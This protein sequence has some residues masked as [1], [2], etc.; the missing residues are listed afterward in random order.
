[1]SDLNAGS[2]PGH[3]PDP[4]PADQIP[5][6]FPPFGPSNPGEPDLFE[7]VVITRLLG[8]KPERIWIHVLLFALTLAATTYIGAGNWVAF[9][10]RFGAV[11]P[12][13]EWPVVLWNGLW[14]SLTL[15]LIL[16]AHEAG[17]Y[18]ACRYYRINASL[19]YFLPA[20][21]PFI[22]GTFGAFIRIREPIRTKTM[23]FD[24]GAAGPF[25]GFLVAV[26]ALVI[27]CSLSNI[28]RLPP[29]FSG[30]ELGEPLLFKAVTSLVWGR[31]PDG[32]SINLHPMAFAAWFGLLVT[33]LNLIPIGQFDGGHISYAAFGKRSVWVTRGAVGA[34]VALCFHS[35]SWIMWTA[36]AVALLVLFGWRHPPTEDED[37]PLDPARRWLAVAALLILILCF[38]PSPME[39]LQLIGR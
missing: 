9:L 13:F 24:M 33:A 18:L 31:V 23:L 29:N 15:L 39:P 38:T 11:R 26:P 25:A 17:H 10:S 32:Y 20:P 12:R 5:I 28:A 22:A 27:G 30:W 34:A 16:G 14:Y 4:T 21:P 36:L 6:E 37:V 7:P 1:V 2:L 8:R 19:P 35:M 3:R